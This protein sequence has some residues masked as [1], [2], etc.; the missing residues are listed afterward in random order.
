[1][2][3]QTITHSPLSLC[4]VDRKEIAC[5]EVSQVDVAIK[6]CT[7]VVEEIQMKF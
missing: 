1:M 5:G 7:D 6:C 4:E 2:G 3:V